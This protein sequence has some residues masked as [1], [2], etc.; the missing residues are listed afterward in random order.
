[1]VLL[2]YFFLEDFLETRFGN[3][4]LLGVTLAN[5]LATS[6]SLA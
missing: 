1:M 6:G 5:F 2:C 4:A 3:F